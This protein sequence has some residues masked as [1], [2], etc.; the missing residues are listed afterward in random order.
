[1]SPEAQMAALGAVAANEYLEGR[2]DRNDAA[3]IQV[4]CWVFLH[5]CIAVF[6]YFVVEN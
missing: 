5:F 2:D 4:H 1:M 3:R 6:L